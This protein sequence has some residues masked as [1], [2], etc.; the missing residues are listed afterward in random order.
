MIV[1]FVNRKEELLTLETLYKSEKAQ[2]VIVYGR[3]RVGKTRLLLEFLKDKNG[4]Y[5]YI[6]RGGE[7]TILNELS[8]SIE[9]EFFKGFKFHH[10]TD[11]L[12][13]L[14]KKFK[15]KNIVVIDEFQRLTEVDGAISMIQK[16]WDEKFLNEKAMLVLSGSS[17]GTIKKV[18][19]KGDA[20]LYGRRT[21]TIEVKPLEFIY[22]KH[23]FPNF[24]S[25]E[26]VKIYSAFGGTPAY[27]EKIDEKITVDENIIKLIL[28]RNGALYDEPEY[29]LLEELRVPSHYMDILTAISFGKCSFSEISE[30]TKIKREN[31]TTYLNSLEILGLISKE[32]PVLVEKKRSRYLIN[33]PFFEFWFRFVKPN[34]TILE[35][36]L[37]EKLWI[38]IKDDF[39]S[40]VGRVFERISKEFIVSMVKSGEIKI[41]A[42][43]IGKWQYGKDEIDLLIYS[44]KEDK[45]MLF[46]VKWKEIDYNNA[47]NILLK[48]IEKSRLVRIGKKE[49][50]IIAKKLYEKEKIRKENFIVIDL[51]DMALGVSNKC[52][53]P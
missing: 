12:E 33:D 11:F 19:L 41:D 25:E 10:F 1:R 37:E 31:L 2:L 40:Y 20:P 50:G 48:L 53:L 5:F 42:D 32:Y 28:R 24:N 49:Y 15:E 14:Y 45:G 44:S 34:K 17:I 3:R 22:L 9:K 23:W 6:P 18:A 38:N 35:L 47:K 26:L 21:C 29:L 51:D 4:L 36:G 39:N 13:Y 30:F 16:F 43:V 52:F 46:E 8:K 7:E 27:L